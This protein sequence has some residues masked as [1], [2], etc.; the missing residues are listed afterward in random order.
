MHPTAIYVAKQHLDSHD[1]NPNDETFHNLFIQ[2]TWAFHYPKLK[3]TNLR[4][5]F[6]CLQ[7]YLIIVVHVQV[8][9]TLI[10]AK[11]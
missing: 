11:R 2:F 5:I 6:F 10:I 7:S 1:S 4:Y 9:S 3:Q 8:S